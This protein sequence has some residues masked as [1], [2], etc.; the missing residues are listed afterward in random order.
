VAA[1]KLGDAIR[2][3]VVWSTGAFLVLW[4][5]NP[6]L[7]A[8]LQY[9]MT[10][11]LAFSEE[12]YGQTLAL[13]AVGSIAA[14]VAY[15]FYCRK[16]SFRTLLHA[17]IVLGIASTVAYW[18]LV[19][20]T[21]AILISLAVGFTY[22]SATLVQLDLAARAC[23]LISAGTVFAMLMAASNLSLSLAIWAGGTWY[24]RFEARFGAVS[25]FNLLVAIGA[26]FNAGCW[27]VLPLV[28]RTLAA[29]D[30]EITDDHAV[31][32]GSDAANSR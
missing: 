31:S 30:R 29:A 10:H 24:E 12:F 15:P 26:G 32:G 8:V 1:R 6:F 7:N 19:D 22:M 5:F 20:K 21:S 23:P 3:P 17:S 18:L 28:H 11:R 14:S 13:Q 2:L 16:F 25:G 27:L 4:N 9:H